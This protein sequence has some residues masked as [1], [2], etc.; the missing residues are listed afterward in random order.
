MVLQNLKPSSL[1]G[2]ALRVTPR[3]SLKFSRAKKSTTLVT[4]C[5][6]GDS[7]VSNSMNLVKELI[8]SSIYINV[9]EVLEVLCT[10]VCCRRSFL[11]RQPQIRD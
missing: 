4:K 5:E 6:I 1:F 11:Q 3:S 10:D 2:E 8:G 7:L 9:V